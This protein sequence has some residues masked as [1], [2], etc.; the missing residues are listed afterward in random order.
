[1]N[2][3][4]AKGAT[5]ILMNPET[6]EILAMASIPSFDPNHPGDYP[7]EH[8]RIKAIADQFEPGSTF[9]I[10]S[11]TAA[12]DK[13]MVRIDDEFFCENG[14]FFYNGHRIRDHEEYGLL[15]FSQVLEQSSNVG[16]IKITELLQGQSLYQYI[17]KFGFGIETDI[18]LPGETRG[19]IREPKNWSKISPGVISMGQE[20]V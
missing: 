10:V 7:L 8:Q 16:I 17:K 14:S 1:M 5:G 2:A 19:F 13:N 18:N 11:A 15:T 20:I 6:G 4:N 12:L 3:T 9:K